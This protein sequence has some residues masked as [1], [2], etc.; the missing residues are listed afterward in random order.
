VEA[1]M[2]LLLRKGGDDIGT[3]VASDEFLALLDLFHGDRK[4]VFCKSFLKVP[5]CLLPLACERAGFAF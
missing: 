3:V 5:V 1:A 4:T 2:N